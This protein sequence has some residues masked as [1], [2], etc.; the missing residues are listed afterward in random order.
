MD[1]CILPEENVDEQYFYYIQVRLEAAY[2]VV[3]LGL[4]ERR[5]YHLTMDHHNGYSPHSLDCDLFVLK[6]PRRVLF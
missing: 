1:H 6:D 3:Q 5:H 2:A 4:Q